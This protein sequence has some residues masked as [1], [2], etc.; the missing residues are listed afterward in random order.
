MDPWNIQVV[1]PSAGLILKFE[2]WDNIRS[3]APKRRSFNRARKWISDLLKRPFKIPE[4]EKLR[5]YDT[6]KALDDMI[7]ALAIPGGKTYEEYLISCLAPMPIQD[8][9]QNSPFLSTQILANTKVNEVTEGDC[10]EDFQD[11]QEKSSVSDVKDPQSHAVN[12]HEEKK[13]LK[14]EICDEP[15]S[16]QHDLNIHINDVH[17]GKNSNKCEICGS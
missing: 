12:I 6:A 14:C 2:S 1:T 11:A 3:F 8:Q 5:H 10:E 13:S 4:N 9:V 7:N 17:K 15:F 16:G